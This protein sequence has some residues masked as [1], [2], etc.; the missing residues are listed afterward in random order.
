MVNHVYDEI[1]RI[2]GMSKE[3][4]DDWYLTIYEELQSHNMNGL[5]KALTSAL[6]KWA[7]IG[8][9]SSDARKNFHG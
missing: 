9:K 6:H 3:E 4:D 7:R 5:S 8:K 1:R 2:T